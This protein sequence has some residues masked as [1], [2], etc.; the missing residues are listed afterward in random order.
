VNKP[1][2]PSSIEELLSTGLPTK[3]TF[4]TAVS[5]NK[6]VFGRVCSRL[7]S[8]GIPSFIF[9]ETASSTADPIF[10]LKASTSLQ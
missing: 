5:S 9:L 4:R 8:V 10:P 2:I 1:L 6:I 7:S 3:E